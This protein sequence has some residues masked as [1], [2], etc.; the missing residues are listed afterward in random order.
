MKIFYSAQSRRVLEALSSVN[1]KSFRELG[2]RGHTLSESVPPM[3]ID[4]TMQEKCGC[5]LRLKVIGSLCLF[6][7]K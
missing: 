5:D 4:F 7:E 6:W 2:I 3:I 1:V